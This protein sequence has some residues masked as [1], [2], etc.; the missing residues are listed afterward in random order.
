MKP[1]KPCEN[2]GEYAWIK[3]TEA[4]GMPAMYLADNG[5]WSK[6]G[7]GTSFV[8]WRCTKCM[9]VRIFSVSQIPEKDFLTE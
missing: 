5:K 7:G 6:F 8:L 2:C 3:Y 9:N 1:N 4:Y